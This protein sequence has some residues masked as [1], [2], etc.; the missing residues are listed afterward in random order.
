VTDPTAPPVVG[1]VAELAATVRE[2][3]AFCYRG[4]LPQ[5]L[6]ALSELA[7]LAAR[8]PVLLE[9]LEV[10]RAD[11]E[12]WAEAEEQ[13]DAYRVQSEAQASEALE[14]IET[15]TYA[16]NETLE[17]IVAMKGIA[18]DALAA[19]TTPNPQDT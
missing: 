13:R 5:A 8:V 14:Q 10:E 7:A 6:A 17:A 11:H 15:T 9:R 12:V 18:R 4:K 19:A 2:A 3:L 1:R 16:L